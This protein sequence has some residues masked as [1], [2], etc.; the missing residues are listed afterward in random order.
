MLFAISNLARAL[1]WWAEEKVFWDFDD[2]E[3][4]DPLTFVLRPP[5][6][7]KSPAMM[8]PPP[9]S[10]KRPATTLGIDMH[11]GAATPSSTIVYPSVDEVLDGHRDEKAQPAGLVTPEVERKLS[12]GEGDLH[13]QVEQARML[14]VVLE[15]AL[16]GD[17]VEWVNPAWKKVVG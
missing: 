7:V 13:A 1:E 2:D 8:L 5:P 9:S 15:L 6:R 10:F 14:N 4:A 3:N 17:L 16:D 12:S 11:P